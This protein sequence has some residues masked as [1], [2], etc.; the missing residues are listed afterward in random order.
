ML[1]TWCGYRVYLVTLFINMLCFVDNNYIYAVVFYNL[2]V[3]YGVCNIHVCT[4]LLNI[5][6]LHNLSCACQR[7]TSRGW[8]E[9]H[10]V[11]P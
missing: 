8:P 4:G 3:I 10:I 9:I 2:K 6:S 1:I 7:D 5:Q 11:L